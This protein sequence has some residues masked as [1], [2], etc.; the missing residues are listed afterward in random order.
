MHVG[1]ILFI[2]VIGAGIAYFALL[3]T[4]GAGPDWMWKL[5]RHDP[6]RNLFF[7]Q[8]GSWRQHA[9]IGILGVLA[10]WALLAAMAAGLFAR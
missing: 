6:V 7:R 4:R 5:G 2:L 1:T 10:A 9:K 8:D 3:W